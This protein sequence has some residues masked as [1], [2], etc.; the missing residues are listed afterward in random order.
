MW[1]KLTI[2]VVVAALLIFMSL[3]STTIHTTVVV[4]DPD[5]PLP[6]PT[7]PSPLS[8][9]YWAGMHFTLGTFVRIGVIIFVTT[10]IGAWIIRKQ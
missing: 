5:D 3:P 2:L 8:R 1:W 9:A 6:K 7:F 4:L 10:C